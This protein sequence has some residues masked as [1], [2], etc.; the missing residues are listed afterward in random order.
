MIPK[1][2]I[3]G[4]RIASSI[5]STDKPL[6]SNVTEGMEEGMVELVARHVAEL[7]AGLVAE[8]ISELVA[9]LVSEA[10]SESPVR[11]RKMLFFTSSSSIIRRTVRSF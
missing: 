7:V 3:C 8:L 6:A 9:G 5:F 4:G 10:I 11:L 2:K 1:S